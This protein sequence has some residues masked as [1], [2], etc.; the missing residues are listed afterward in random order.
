MVIPMTF[1]VRRRDGIGSTQSCTVHVTPCPHIQLV[2]DVT[3]SRPSR[4]FLSC[5][6]VSATLYFSSK[7][8]GVFSVGG[9]S[10]ARLTSAS[11]SCWRSASSRC[12]ATISRMSWTS[13]SLIWMRVGFLPILERK[14]RRRVHPRRIATRRNIG[15]FS[16]TGYQFIHLQ[17]TKK[18]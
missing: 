18:K 12:C 4:L 15:N 17:T 2:E 13:R 9:F 16:I 1:A 10:A 5:C 8:A 11:A 14:E 3:V 6:L 7:S